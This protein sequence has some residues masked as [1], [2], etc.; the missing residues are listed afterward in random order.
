MKIYVWSSDNNSDRVEFEAQAD[1]YAFVVMSVKAKDENEVEHEV[2]IALSEDEAIDLTDQLRSAR[3]Q[4][5]SI[6]SGSA[7]EASA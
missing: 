3:L 6:T 2:R 4:A 1:D 5:Q 7:E